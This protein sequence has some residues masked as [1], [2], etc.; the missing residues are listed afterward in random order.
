MRAVQ[1]QRRLPNHAAEARGLLYRWH[2]FVECMTVHAALAVGLRVAAGGWHP[3]ASFAAQRVA[4][5]TVRPAT[6]QYLLEPQAHQRRRPVP[7]DRVLPDDELGVPEQLLLRA[8]IDGE[9]RIALVQR[10]YFNAVQGT[11]RR[12][13]QAAG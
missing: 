11:H 12:K 13:E 10:A 3:K 4:A 2:E 6:R 1:N 8:N 5:L 7:V 9:I